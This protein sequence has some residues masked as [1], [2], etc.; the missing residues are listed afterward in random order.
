MGKL[1]DKLKPGMS[2]EEVQ[3]IIGKPRTFFYENRN[4]KVYWYY[5]NSKGLLEITFLNDKLE[6]FL[7]YPIDFLEA[8]K[9]IRASKFYNQYLGKLV[10]FL[11]IGMSFE[12][13][14]K[15]IGKPFSKKVST[16]NTE[17]IKFEYWYYNNGN[18]SV[19]EITFE[20]GKLFNSSIYTHNEITPSMDEMNRQKEI[21]ENPSNEVLTGGFKINLSKEGIEKIRKQFNTWN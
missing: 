11:K 14:Q 2:L 12:E 10:T 15:A 9:E 19:L 21:S 20:N 7:I 3:G 16:Y 1:V 18:K 6:S 5:Q 13:V 4:N 8:H 17:E